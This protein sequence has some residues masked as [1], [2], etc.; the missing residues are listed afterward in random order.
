MQDPKYYVVPL[1]LQDGTANGPE[2]KQFS[3][4]AQREEIDKFCHLQV[5][6]L[7]MKG[8]ISFK[9]ISL[10]TFHYRDIKV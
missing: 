6:V 9:T 5:E 3:I 10:T 4:T 7:E 8:R 2:D 1:P